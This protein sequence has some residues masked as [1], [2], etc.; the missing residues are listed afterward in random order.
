MQAIVLHQ[1]GNKNNYADLFSIKE[2]PAPGIS[3]DE[4]L[5][6][7]FNASLNHRDLWIAEGAYSKIKLPV[8]LG[9]DGAGIIYEKGKNV[10]NFSTGDKVIIYPCSNWGS[11]ENFQNRNFE[12]LGMPADGAFA[13]YLK[14][15]SSAVFKFPEHLDFIQASAFPLAGLTAYRSLFVKAEIKN[16]DNVLITGTGG[17]V[18]SFALMFALI[19]GAK[20]FVTSG[21]DDKIKKAVSLGA[22]GGVNYKSADWINELKDITE[23]KIDIVIDGSG[24]KYF[25]GY[26]DLCSYGARIVSYGAT[27]GAA[28]KLDLHKVYWKQLKILGSTMGTV[29]DFINMLEFADTNKSIPIIDKVFPFKEYLK[30]FDRM[31]DSEQFG[32]IVLEFAK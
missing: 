30:A 9:S 26:V 32:K 11:N 5:I 18:A 8:I 20:V 2:V 25:S 4:V 15:H 17:G 23:N 19:A 7:I 24:G 10:N 28:G 6:K 21:S 12:I 22:E 31:K 13:E 14:V 29:S 3:D 16:T 1:T 27:L